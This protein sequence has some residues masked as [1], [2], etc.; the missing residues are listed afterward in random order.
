MK[1]EVYDYENIMF[2]GTLYPRK[3]ESDKIKLLV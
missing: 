3:F 1:Y 2:V